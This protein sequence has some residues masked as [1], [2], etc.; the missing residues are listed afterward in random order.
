[1]KGRKFDTIST[2]S[3]SSGTIFKI[4]DYLKSK[5]VKTNFN[6]KEIIMADL[7][8]EI[9]SFVQKV[10]AGIHT[11][12]ID[13]VKGLSYSEKIATDILTNDLPV[14]EAVAGMVYPPAEDFLSIIAQ[15]L[16]AIEANG[17]NA[18]ATAQLI[19][20]TITPGANVSV[21]QA[22]AIVASAQM[23]EA[24]T[25]ASI[26]DIKSKIQATFN[27]VPKAA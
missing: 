18:S 15:I 16:A 8:T 12:F 7:G 4:W 17:K 25:A 10:I 27:Y 6:E 22:T 5:I 19:A 20:S 11:V 13:L 2:Y 21:K 3:V 26:A 14:A 24:A 23:T 1:M 9:S